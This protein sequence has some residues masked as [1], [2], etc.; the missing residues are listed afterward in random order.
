M[1]ESINDVSL[2]FI[3]MG[4]TML[5]FCLIA[6]G[7]IIA[8]NWIREM[9]K[10]YDEHAAS[11]FHHFKLSADTKMI[12]LVNLLMCFVTV[13]ISLSVWS[14]LVDAKNE[15]NRRDDF[16]SI[17]EEKK[18]LMYQLKL[19][20]EA[21]DWTIGGKQKLTKYLTDQVLEEERGRN[22]YIVQ[23]RNKKYVREISKTG[24]NYRENTS[25]LQTA[26]LERGL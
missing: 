1:L 4:L 24:E 23:E 22:D 15:I 2:A 6:A 26:W 3:F 12:A 10:R 14:C 21:A 16:A 11:G 8:K 18:I 7:F 25:G 20:R 13:I 19:Y 9:F 17:E 5:G